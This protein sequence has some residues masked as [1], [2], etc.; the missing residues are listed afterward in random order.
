MK[1]RLVGEHQV[2]NGSIN[3]LSLS[4]GIYNPAKRADSTY[5]VISLCN[6]L[7]TLEVDCVSILNFLHVC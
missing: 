6:L 1:V 5:Q 3:D 4:T 2:I 7:L